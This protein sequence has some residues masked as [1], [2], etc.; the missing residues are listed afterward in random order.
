[1]AKGKGGC[2]SG[3]EV[4]TNKP[5]KR[6]QDSQTLLLATGQD[7]WDQCPLS[8]LI[9]KSQPLH[10]QKVRTQ[11]LSKGPRGHRCYPHQEGV[12]GPEGCE[13]TCKEHESSCQARG[14]GSPETTLEQFRDQSCLPSSPDC[15]SAKGVLGKLSLAWAG[16]WDY[17]GYRLGGALE[18][19]QETPAAVGPGWTMF[20]CVCARVAMCACTCA[21]V[22]G[23]ESFRP[24]ASRDKRILPNHH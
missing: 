22:Y 14:S 20:P 6:H 19:Q 17:E 16:E 4:K 7:N 10:I 9:P 21:H 1:M 13:S 2:P 5:S 8:L 12:P 23:E 15:S 24:T 18:H 3:K 11:G